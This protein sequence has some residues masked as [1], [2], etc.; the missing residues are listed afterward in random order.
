[1]GDSC[2]NSA[3]FDQAPIEDEPDESEESP[4]D[5]TDRSKSKR[6]SILE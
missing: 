3:G 6:G 4:E 1:M 5:D 2:C